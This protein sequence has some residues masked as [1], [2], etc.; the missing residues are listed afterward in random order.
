MRALVLGLAVGLA[1]CAA[2]SA[3]PPRLGGPPADEQCVRQ[4]VTSNQMRAVGPQVILQD[5]EAEC[6]DWDRSSAPQ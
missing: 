1:G 4:C 5:C 6:R 3:P 2:S